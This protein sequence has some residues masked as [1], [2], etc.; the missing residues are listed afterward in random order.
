[1]AS[2]KRIE[3]LGGWEGYSLGTVGRMPTGSR[4]GEDVLIELH[5]IRGRPRPWG[6]CG[7]SVKA[8]H[9]SY[10]RWVRGLPLLDAQTWLLVHRMRV[11]CPTCGP[12]PE[13]L[14]WLAPYARRTRRLEDS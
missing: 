1:M 10:E 12:K 14:S 4:A 8:I 9:D 13:D 6:G 7:Q 3:V 5:P 11:D 2:A